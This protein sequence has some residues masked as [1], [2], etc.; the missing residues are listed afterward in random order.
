VLYTAAIL[1]LKYGPNDDQAIREE[2]LKAAKVSVARMF[3]FG[4]KNKSKPGPLLEKARDL[5]ERLK[6]ELS[7]GDDE[8]E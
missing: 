4:K 5:Y 6:R 2:R 8:D 3:G 1:E 7:E